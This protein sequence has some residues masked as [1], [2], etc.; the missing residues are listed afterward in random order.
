M[1]KITQQKIFEKIQQ[2]DEYLANLQ[3]LKKEIKNQKEFAEDFHFYGLAERF[4]QLCVQT[5]IDT[6][7]LVIIE[8]EIEK[9]ED[10]K[11]TISLLFNKKIISEN[12]AM[13]FEGLVGFRNILV[14][15]YGKI[16]REKVYQYLMER[17]EDFEVFKKEIGK[18]LKN[19]V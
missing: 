1:T 4:L 18:W 19:I 10:N 16:D 14:H 8:E 12:L 13:R 2:L 17:L 15:E 6:F 3:K 5:I 9:P 7:N 11:E